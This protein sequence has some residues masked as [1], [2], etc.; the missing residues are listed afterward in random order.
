MNFL[1]ISLV[2]AL[3]VGIFYQWKTYDI[4][5]LYLVKSDDAHKSGSAQPNGWGYINQ[6]GS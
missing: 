6:A 1:V 2:S 3:S 4:L 5:P